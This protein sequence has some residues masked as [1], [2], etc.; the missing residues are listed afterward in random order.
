MSFAQIQSELGRLEQL[1]AALIHETATATSEDR[2]RA[3]EAAQPHIEPKTI[4]AEA[5]LQS[6]YGISVKEAEAIIKERDADPVRWPLEEYRKAQ[7][8]LQAYHA[9]PEQRR[10]SSTRAGWRRTRGV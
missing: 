1:R 8:M 2:I 9:K 5:L 6:G 4:Q 3:L 10:P 7:A